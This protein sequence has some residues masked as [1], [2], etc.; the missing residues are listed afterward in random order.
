MKLKL[1]LFCGLA[2]AGAQAMACY[3]VYDSNSR[4]IY[5]GLESPVD[6]SLQ[7]HQTLGKRF[8]GAHMVFDQSTI[9]T[10]VALAQ[11]ARPTGRD[12]PAGTIRMENGRRATP[13]GTSMLFTD[14]E[15]AAR[16]NLPHTVVAGDVVMVPASV[17]A[18]RASIPSIT[19]VPV[20]TAM[21]SAGPDTRSMGAGPAPTVI[22]ELRN[23]RTVVQ[24]GAGVAY[25]R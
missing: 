9:C 12:V 16:Q 1:A 22:T 11:V 18:T 6:M 15:T 7:L 14:R 13:G 4:V 24:R 23:G 2:L 10:P 20:D 5:Q 25:V 21:A 19:V 8:P 3:T 17:A